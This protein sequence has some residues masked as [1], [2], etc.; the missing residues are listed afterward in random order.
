MSHRMDP[1]D[2]VEGVIAGLKRGER[3]FGV[4]SHLIIAFMRDAPGI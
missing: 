4:K 2:Y 1:E 3:D